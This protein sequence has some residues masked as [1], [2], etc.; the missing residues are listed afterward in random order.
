MTA[1]A[2][3]A[4]AVSPAQIAA[5]MREFHFSRMTRYAPAPMQVSAYALFYACRDDERD[6][7]LLARISKLVGEDE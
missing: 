7:V 3:T 5:M 1:G 6:S 2:V 4:R